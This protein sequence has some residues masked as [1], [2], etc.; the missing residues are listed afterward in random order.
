M[1]QNTR[2]PRVSPWS[3][4]RDTN[5]EPDAKALA[6]RRSVGGARPVRPPF[7]SRGKTLAPA[8]R[9]HSP[10]PVASRLVFG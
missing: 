7:A 6:S 10:L 5:S 9:G 4:T 3:S 1:T 2:S 8:C